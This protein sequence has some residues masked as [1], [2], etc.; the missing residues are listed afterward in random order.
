MNRPTASPPRNRWSADSAPSTATGR[1]AATSFSERKRPSAASRAGPIRQAFPVMP[2]TGRS[3]ATRRPLRTS[4]MAAMDAPTSAQELQRARIAS[5]SARVRSRRFRRTGQ[6]SLSLI[7]NFWMKNEWLPRPRR[8]AD[9]NRSSPSTTAV[10]VTR[11]PML[12]AIPRTVRSVRSRWTRRDERAARK[13]SR[14]RMAPLPEG[15]GSWRLT[16]IVT[17]RSG[18]SVRRVR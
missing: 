16:S 18:L 14:G 15:Q 3:R 8:L 2:T 6:A 10:T 13:T 5:T 17:R 4:R 11:D 12:T 7:V 1:A 9:T